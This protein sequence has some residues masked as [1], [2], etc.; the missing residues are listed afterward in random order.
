MI[1][2]P[3]QDAVDTFVADWAGEFP[4]LDFS[5]LAVLGR[6][7]R[8]GNMVEQELRE[9]LAAAG[10]GGG[11]FDVLAALRRVGEPF[12]LNA[13][14]LGAVMSVTPGA[15]TKRVDRLV[16]AGLVVRA[17][18]VDDRRGRLVELTE[19]GREVV[20]R[21]VATTSADRERLL[22]SVSPEERT[23]LVRLLRILL[24]SLEGPDR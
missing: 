18:A 13:S 15:V 2:S 8:I 22:M 1:D 14:E 11:D 3:V 24:V 10:L 6:I 16:A 9:P 23:E 19:S 4:D 17:V 5:A 21:L 12:R 20:D 7:Q